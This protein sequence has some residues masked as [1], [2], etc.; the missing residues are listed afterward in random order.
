[1]CASNTSYLF[2]CAVLSRY[3]LYYAEQNAK[4]KMAWVPTTDAQARIYFYN[5]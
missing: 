1:M 3:A 5:L 4:N 2:V